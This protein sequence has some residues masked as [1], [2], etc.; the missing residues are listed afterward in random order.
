MSLI[1]VKFFSKFNE[2]HVASSFNI[3]HY[4]LFKTLKKFRLLKIII[5][6]VS[7]GAINHTK[8]RIDV[9]LTST[10]ENCNIFRLKR[11]KK[12]F[13]INYLAIETPNLKRITQNFQLQCNERNG[14]S[15]SA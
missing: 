9:A 13:S 4:L 6:L 7:R 1:R 2:F 14:L 8:Q 11:V 3:Q 5:K 12:N 10:R 15:S